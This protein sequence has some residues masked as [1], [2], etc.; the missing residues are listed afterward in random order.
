[1]KE[2]DLDMDSTQA[3]LDST[4]PDTPDFVDSVIQDSEEDEIFFG[5]TSTKEKKGRNAKFNRRDTICLSDGDRR[6]SFDVAKTKS[7]DLLLSQQTSK[8]RKSSSRSSLYSQE[9]SIM[10]EED[11]DDCVFMVPTVQ[12]GEISSTVFD[13]CEELELEAGRNGRD[14]RVQEEQNLSLNVTGRRYRNKKQ[15]N[16]LKS[17]V[18]LPSVSKMDAAMDDIS[19]EG[20]RRAGKDHEVE[21]MD[22]GDLVECRRENFMEV[23]PRLHSAGGSVSSCET[24][25]TES[26][27]NTS[28]SDLGPELDCSQVSDIPVLECSTVSDMGENLSADTSSVSD[29]PTDSSQVSDCPTNT[30]KM[31]DGEVSGKVFAEGSADIFSKDDSVE[32]ESVHGNTAAVSCSSV[33]DHTASSDISHVDSTV[34]S[35]VVTF[36]EDTSVSGVYDS[37]S[38]DTRDEFIDDTE[39]Q[40]DCDVDES[41]V[42]EGEV[43]E[44]K[45]SDVS[46]ELFNDSDVTKFA[47]VKRNIFEGESDMESFVL[48]S[49]A[50]E[51]DSVADNPFTLG[52]INDDLNSVGNS[53][54]SL[55]SVV[56]GLGSVV[57]GNLGH[58]G[59][60]MSMTVGDDSVFSRNSLQGHFTL[61]HSFDVAGEESADETDTDTVD[62]NEDAAAEESLHDQSEE[63]ESNDIPHILL[64]RP[65]LPNNIADDDE[66]SSSPEF[67]PASP[68]RSA[69][70]VYQTAPTSHNATD[71]S[72]MFDT[73][74]EEMMLFEMYGENYDEMVEDMSKQ[75]KLALKDKLANRG[76]EEITKVAEKLHKIMQEKSRESSIGSTISPFS[77]ASSTPSFQI[78]PDPSPQPTDPVYPPPVLVENSTLPPLDQ[79]IP[80]E[81]RGSTECLPES[82]EF[83]VRKV[84]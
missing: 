3:L 17:I 78:P 35:G 41:N 69:A 30:S 24:G 81:L 28:Q 42:V 49:V 21:M 32:K 50:S 6:R 61:S 15:R 25:T 73:T 31:T 83:R 66:R 53:S 84:Q 33:L 12:V 4:I 36:K 27:G 7:R 23:N 44:E 16:N 70:S 2:S 20:E 11:E 18:S 71:L 48:G 72:P 1:M 8:G 64:T 39:V 5:D 45:S 10:E 76:E 43:N 80:K 22:E 47:N 51:L 68:D 19:M 46:S 55:G 58:D 74:A 79:N 38:D 62:G 63:M 34:N 65:S 13:E 67:L 37:F 54:F 75:Q 77:V 29:R 57:A 9:N 59:G 82:Q 26:E 60:E 52:S 56:S 40:D 14:S